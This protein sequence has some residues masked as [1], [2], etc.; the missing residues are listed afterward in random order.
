MGNRLTK[1]FW[2]ALLNFIT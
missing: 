2:R 1:L